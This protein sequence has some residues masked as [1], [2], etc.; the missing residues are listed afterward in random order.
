MGIAIFSIVVTTLIMTG[1]FY[2]H[3]KTQVFSDLKVIAELLSEN[4]EY[5]KLPEDTRVT[6]IDNDGAVIFDSMAEAGIMENHLDRPEV[7]EALA[8][9]RGQSIRKSDTL[10]ENIFYYA[11]KM[12]SGQVLRV[13]KKSA[14][15]A[16]FFISVIPI[17]VVVILILVIICVMVSRYLTSEIVA[18]I[19]RMVEDMEHVDE[20]EIY[21]ELIPFT[22][23]IRS[24]HEEIL[25]AANMRQEFTANISHELKTPLT[26]ISGYAELMETGV[27]KETD[28]KHFSHEIGKSSDRLLILINDIIKLSELDGE[29]NEELL[30]IVDLAEVTRGT[31]EMLSINAAKMNVKISYHGCNTAWIRIGNEL[32]EELAYNLIENAIRYNKPGGIVKVSVH[33]EKNKVDLVVA[34]TGIGIPKEHQERIFERFYRVDKGRSKQLGGTGL[35]LSIVKHICNLTRGIISLES[36][37]GEGTTIKIEWDVVD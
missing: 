8:K 31:V 3:L 1:I 17:T 11:V 18:P 21:E 28:I 23:K 9:G 34:D 25:F 10:S 14:S 36:N 29:N 20:N 12:E 32:A 6:V 16:W 15:V 5:D 27:V 30:E 22:K 19:E 7:K 4:K 26:A 37:A 35:G 2:I 33:V 13:G 24:Q